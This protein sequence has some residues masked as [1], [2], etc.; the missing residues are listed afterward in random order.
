MTMILFKDLL[1]LAQLKSNAFKII[2]EYFDLTKL[3][4]Q[5]LKMNASLAKQREVNL[6]GPVFTQENDKFFF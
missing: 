3:V 1:D 2:Y 5:G 4:N 6:L